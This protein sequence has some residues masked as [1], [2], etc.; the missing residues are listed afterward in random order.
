MSE[1]GQSVNSA[2]RNAGVAVPSAPVPPGL[3]VVDPAK[4]ENGL[5]MIRLPGDNVLLS[6]FSAKIGGVLAANGVYRREGVPVLFDMDTNRLE[7]VEAQAFRSFVEDYAVCFTKK[8]VGDDEWKNVGKTMTSETAKGVLRSPAFKRELAP[9]SRVNPVRMPVQRADG[10]IQLLAPGYDKESG[11]LTLDSGF[12]YDETFTLDEARTALKDLLSEFP[13]PDRQPDGTSRSEAVIIAAL[14]ANFAS[15]LLPSMMNRVNFGFMANSEGSGK[16]LLA[17]LCLIPVFG[18]A[19]VTGTPDNKEEF[20]KTL[21]T[22]AL[23]ASPYLFLDDLS[24]LLRNNLLNAFMTAST[25]SGRVMGGQQ[26]FSAPKVATVFITGNNLE[27]S[28]DIARRTLQVELFVTSANPQSREIK[29]LINARYLAKPEN[30]RQILSA[31]WAMVRAWDAK[32]RPPATRVLRGFEAWSN[33]YGGIV[34]NAGFGNPLDEPPSDAGFGDTKRHDM[35]ALVNKL[36]EGVEKT[37]EFTFDSLIDVARDLNCFEFAID[38]KETKEG[39]ELKQGSKSVMGKMFSKE[40][41]GRSFQLKDGRVVTFG[42]RGKN[43]SRKYTLVV[44]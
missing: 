13:I 39:F 1:Q 24:G 33:I 3:T 16:T 34:Q 41:G 22:A 5:P 43:R 18:S 30:R 38:G 8:R 28:P 37:A 25:W 6:D 9:L 12:E 36:A 23:S 20:R 35:E 44:M 32:D 7:P 27:L 17:E 15:M 31:L 42:N 40:Y 26:K 14:L 29:R 21:D 11:A 2:L 19:E 4:E 10:T